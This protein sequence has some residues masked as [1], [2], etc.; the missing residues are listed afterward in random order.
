LPVYISLALNYFQN[1]AIFSDNAKI[2]GKTLRSP[3]LTDLNHH[4]NRHQNVNNQEEVG[5]RQL[6][7]QSTA[8]IIMCQ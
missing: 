3:A 6:V 5:A 8:T 2:I 7:K 4:L 1:K